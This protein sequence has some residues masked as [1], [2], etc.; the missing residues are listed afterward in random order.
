V[1]S[2]ASLRNLIR[3]G[4]VDGG[5]FVGGLFTVYLS[6]FIRQKGTGTLEAQLSTGRRCVEA[7]FSNP[8]LYLKTGRAEDAQK[9]HNS[10]PYLAGRVAAASDGP[11]AAISSKPSEFMRAARADMDVAL[12]WIWKSRRVLRSG[13]FAEETFPMRGTYRRTERGSNP[14]LVFNQ[15]GLRQH[16]TRP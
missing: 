15:L 2:Q 6:R 4:G 7:W 16:P 11:A 13:V 14:T 3:P 5:L 8:I 1:R 9:A 10:V 12:K